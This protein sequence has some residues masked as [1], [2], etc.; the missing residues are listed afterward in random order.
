MWGGRC[1]AS[2]EFNEVRTTIHNVTSNSIEL[3]VTLGMSCVQGVC[4]GCVCV[5]A[6]KTTEKT[7]ASYFSQ[8]MRHTLLTAHQGSSAS[9]NTSQWIA[10]QA[11]TS[12]RVTCRDRHPM[13]P[14]ARRK[15][16]LS[17]ASSAAGCETGRPAFPL[18]R[19]SVGCAYNKHDGYN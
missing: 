16:D 19:D 17:C 12:S 4:N 13:L 9:V 15:R 1:H 14:S 3:N 10:P 8:Q 7:Q 18:S 5:S 11:E 6:T 2:Y